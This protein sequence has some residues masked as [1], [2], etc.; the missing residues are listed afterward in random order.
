METIF[1]VPVGAF[2]LQKVLE[3]GLL[4]D[5]ASGQVDKTMLQS[6]DLLDIRPIQVIFE[7]GRRGEGTIFKPAVGF[8]EAGG[9]DRRLLG[10][11]PLLKQPGAHLLVHWPE[12]RT[13]YPRLPLLTSAGRPIAG[14][15][16]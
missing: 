16:G 2:E 12:R 1:D 10:L 14:V 6:E 7:H 15:E 5:F 4:F 8:I 11:A 3:T 9:A 13:G